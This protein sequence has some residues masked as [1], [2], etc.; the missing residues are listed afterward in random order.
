MTPKSTFLY[1][2]IVAGCAVRDALRGPR[3]YAGRASIDTATTVPRFGARIVERHDCILLY[4]YPV[5]QGFP[6]RGRGVIIFHSSMIMHCLEK[7]R[8]TL[9]HSS[10]DGTVRQTRIRKPHYDLERSLD[11]ALKSLSCVERMLD[12]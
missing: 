4:R 5:F 7:K 8:S 12:N 9:I 11:T 1:Y 3:L 2:M 10:D 6:S